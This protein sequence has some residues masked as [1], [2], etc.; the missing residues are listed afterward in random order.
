MTSCALTP[1]G[2]A[3]AELFKATFQFYSALITIGDRFSAVVGLTTARWQV[4]AALCRTGRPET[5]SN[6][7]RMMGL[8]R[9][10]VQRVADEL[11]YLGLIT[12]EANPYH[13]RAPL[14]LLTKKGEAAYRE[15]RDLRTPWIN[16]LA[17]ALDA[18]E[19]EIVTKTLNALREKLEEHGH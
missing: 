5:V 16:T 12:Y 17:A 11:V 1:E 14:M 13:K 18:E 3:L 9:Q 4:L 8:A 15:I 2:E 6:V 7:A 19:I 10:S